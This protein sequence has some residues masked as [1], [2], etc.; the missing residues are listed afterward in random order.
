MATVEME[1]IS[2]GRI[3]KSAYSTFIAEFGAP[4]AGEDDVIAGPAYWAS[5]ALP[6]KLRATAASGRLTRT[7]LN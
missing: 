1:I 4:A 5:A 3:L 2:P 6:L 7:D